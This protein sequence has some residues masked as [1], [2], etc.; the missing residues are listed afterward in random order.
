MNNDS[1]ILRESAHQWLHRFFQESVAATGPLALSYAL[2]SL[3]SLGKLAE[4]SDANS[5]AKRLQ[6]CQDPVTGYFFDG[7]RDDYSPAPHEMEDHYHLE[8]TTFF[9]LL[10]LHVLKSK[11]SHPLRFLKNR[12]SEDVISWADDLWHSKNP[13]KGERLAHRLLFEVYRTETEENEEAAVS[14]HKILDWLAGAQAANSG[15]WEFDD[16]VESTEPIE[17]AGFLLPFFEYVMRPILRR[18]RMVDA[19]IQIFE[20]GRTSPSA[21]PELALVSA[22]ATVKYQLSYRGEEIKTL[23]V[24]IRDSI[25]QSQKHDGSFHDSEPMEKPDAE[26]LQAVVE[27]TFLRLSTLAIIEQTLAEDLPVDPWQT[28]EW[29]GPGYHHPPASLT[30]HERKVLPLWLRPTAYSASP[31]ETEINS[32]KP[33]ISIVIPCYNLGRYLHEAVESVLKQSYQEFEIIILDDGSTDDFTSWLLKNFDRPKTVVIRQLNAGL[34]A[35]R[36]RGIARASGRYICCLDPDDRLRPEFFAEAVGVLEREPEV[37]LVSGFF[38][39]FDERDDTFRYGSCEFPDLLAYNQAI[40]PAIFRRDVC[41]KA[42]GYCETFSASGIED[43]DLWISFIELGYRA[44]VI[45]E[46][47]WE[48]RIRPDQMST[49]MYEADRWG[50]IFCELVQRHPQSYAKYAPAVLAKQAS[51]WA[52]LR[53]WANECQSATAW[54]ENNSNIWQLRAEKHVRLS[55]DRQRWIDTLIEDKKWLEDQ[56]A[57]FQQL[58]EKRERLLL[59]QQGWIDTLQQDKQWLDDQRMAWQHLAE[60]RAKTIDEQRLWIQ[61]LEKAKVWLEEQSANWQRL[62]ESR[63]IENKN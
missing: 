28:P 44:H 37:G 60:E 53:A 8:R 58:A 18:S 33:I 21:L 43:W 50:R 5:H 11:A 10:A 13:K 20:S 61:E 6:E 45:P 48:Y 47:V 36:N 3:H 1:A 63:E 38:E 30:E 41:E 22:L 25:C 56:K 62:A 55:S 23:F 34:A 17:A 24:R 32:R 31:A 35:T 14:L 52:E 12:R 16:E 54:W 57:S 4:T 7:R 9:A 15:L 59:E 29:P 26:D 49:K 2:L 19:M 27:T 51:R 42:G 40:E 39:M 46:I